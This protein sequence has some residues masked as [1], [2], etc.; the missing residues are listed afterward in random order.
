MEAG[1]FHLNHGASPMQHFCTPKARRLAGALILG[2]ALA[3]CG[4]TARPPGG[5]VTAEAVIAREL[6]ASAERW[7]AGDLEGFLAP[8]L[9]AP[10]TTFVSGGGLLRGR[11]AIEQRYRS[12]YW[13]DGR[14]RDAL[15]FGD[16]EVTLL[17][18]DHALV[19]GRY[20]LYDA[21]GTQ[22]GTGPFTLVYRRT[23]EG[24]RIVHDHSS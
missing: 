21:A 17:G 14:A 6:Q 24:W 11:D 20:L 15:R 19:T 18:A 23:P 7:N 1:H 13:A 5:A 9:D 10:E 4:A 16:L 8:Y 2:A 22:T 12:T 3:G